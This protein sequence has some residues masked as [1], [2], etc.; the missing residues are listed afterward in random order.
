M[1]NV[2]NIPPIGVMTIAIKQM[3]MLS[4]SLEDQLVPSTLEFGIHTLVE[5]RMD[6]SRFD[7]K[8]QSDETDRLR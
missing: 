8:Y 7:E 3:V 6:V 1:I 4:V 2:R 5:D